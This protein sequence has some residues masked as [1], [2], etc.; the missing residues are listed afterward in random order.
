MQS[1]RAIVDLLDLQFAS[2]LQSLRT[3]TLSVPN[4][5]LYRSTPALSVGENIL[6][7][8]GVVEQTCGGLTSNLW[9]DPFEWTLPETLSTGEHILDYLS[10]VVT[11]KERAFACLGNDEVLLK[12]IAVPWSDS[13]QLLELLMQT[14]VKASEYRGRAVATA[15]LLSRIDPM[16][17]IL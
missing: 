6:K 14:L 13:C 8:A 1:Q 17:D 15:E 7:S 4:N 5:L 2:L 10:E 11:A 3:L 12:Y 9:D 16:S